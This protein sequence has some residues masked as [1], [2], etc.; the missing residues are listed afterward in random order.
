MRKRPWLVILLVYMAFIFLN[1]LT[2]ADESS[3]QSGFVLEQVQ[4]FLA[5]AGLGRLGITEH[6]I[7]KAAHFTEYTGLGILLFMCLKQ[8]RFVGWERQFM[9]VTAGFLIPFVDETLQLFTPGRSGQISDVWLD[10]SGVAAGTLIIYLC[11]K[12]G[13]EKRGYRVGKRTKY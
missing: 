2:P 7:R 1:S 4:R 5:F 12:A 6:I 8:Y 13:E 10:V 9:T 11:H 3:R